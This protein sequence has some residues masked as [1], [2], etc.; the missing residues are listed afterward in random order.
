MP[1]TV[2]QL[3]ITERTYILAHAHNDPAR[4]RA[5]A[6]RVFEGRPL[7]EVAHETG[8][9]RST[10]Q[11]LCERFVPL[12]TEWVGMMTDPATADRDLL[13]EVSGMVEEYLGPDR[14]WH[15][16]QTGPARQAGPTGPAGQ[17]GEGCRP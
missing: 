15:D 8:L 12:Y 14:R 13:R 11:S 3:S 17:A 6:L 16:R 7:A 5:I 9:P 10:V 2:S 4:F 1:R